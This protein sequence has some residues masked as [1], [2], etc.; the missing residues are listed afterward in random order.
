MDFVNETKVE[1]GWTLGFEPDGREL[2]VVAIKATYK[3]PE[4]GK[5]PELA[6]TQLPLTEADEFS[7]EPGLSAM[8]YETD[9][10]HRKPQCDVLL[11]G[12]A[13]APQGK[14]AYKVPVALQVGAMKKAFVVVGNRTWRRAINSVKPTNPEPFRVMPFSYGNAFGGVDDTPPDPMKHRTYMPNPVG[15]GFYGNTDVRLMEG[16]P[17]P[18]TE[19]LKNSIAKPDG[20]YQPMALGPMGRNFDPRYKF[21]GTYNQ[22]WLDNQAP[23]WPDDFDYRYFQSA[24]A[25]QQIPYPQGG[26]P[27]VLMNLTPQGNKRFR[28]PSKNMPVHLIPYRGKVQQQNAMIDTVLIEPDQNRFML[29]WRVSYPLRKDCFELQQVVAGEMPRAWQITQKYGDKPYYKGLAE[30]INAKKQKG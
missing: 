28:L 14:F 4:D 12:S 16:K 7:G 2:L 23:F 15:K 11:N 3:I 30:F 1:A 8:L 21:A 22:E 24:P 27:V 26:E 9:Y 25:D 17:L 10:A 13:Y 29:T 19:E 6:E 5:E 18:N 20:K